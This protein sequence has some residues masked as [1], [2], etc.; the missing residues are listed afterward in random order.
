MNEEILKRKIKPYVTVTVDEL[1]FKGYKP[2]IIL[3][4]SELQGGIDILPNNTFSL[5]MNVSYTF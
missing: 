2:D 4:A 5:N 3:V 1:L